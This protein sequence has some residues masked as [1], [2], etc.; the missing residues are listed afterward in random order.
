MGVW[1]ECPGWS[2]CSRWVYGMSVHDDPNAVGGCM[3][4]VSM[5]VRM[6]SV[7][8]RGCMGLVSMMVRMQ[9]VGHRGCM[10]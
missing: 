2:A 3:G 8:H 9:S 4:L 7:G 10:G 5:M 1:D 6:Q